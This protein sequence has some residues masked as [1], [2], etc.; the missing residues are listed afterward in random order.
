MQESKPIDQGDRVVPYPFMLPSAATMG[1]TDEVRTYTDVEF[2][3]MRGFRPLLLDLHITK[4]RGEAVPLVIYLHCGAWLTGSHKQTGVYRCMDG[5][6]TGLLQAG[7]AI[8]AVQ[9]RLSSEAIFPACLHDAVSA[10]RW[11]RRFALELQ[12]DPN[13]F[14][15]W[16]ESAGG[17]L[18]SFLAMNLTDE[19]MLGSLGVAEGDATVQAAVSWYGT[20]D[21]LRNSEQALLGSRPNFDAP[22]APGARLI[23]GAV[24][25]NLDQARRASPLYWVNT[26]AAPMH[27][28][29]GSDDLTTPPQQSLSLCLALQA[30]GVSAQ[31]VSVD[32]ADHELRGIDP[33]LYIPMS[34]DF[35]KKHF[36]L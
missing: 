18:A 10:V 29:H 17:H 19:E 31:V 16:G 15:A 23:G 7:F 1:E 33:S 32:G 13:R 6:I 9:Y 2:A 25:D 24:P 8:A 4:G 28:V 22:D 30:A 36:Q 21:F 11:L 26:Q 35:L 3:M 14:G 27:F 20:T 5:I 12:L 34:I